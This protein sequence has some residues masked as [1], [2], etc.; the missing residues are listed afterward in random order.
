MSEINYCPGNKRQLILIILFTQ[1]YIFSLRAETRH[2][3][4]EHRKHVT[5][6]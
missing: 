5:K 2:C 3:T 6:Q 1:A 4:T